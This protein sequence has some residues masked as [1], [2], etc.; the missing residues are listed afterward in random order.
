MQRRWLSSCLRKESFLQSPRNAC[1]L[2]N[3]V[4][5]EDSVT[6][7]PSSAKNTS[8]SQKGLPNLLSYPLS[9]LL[10]AANVGDSG[11]VVSTIM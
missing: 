5:I 4:V 11:Y 3:P 8:N 1:Y 2:G 6:V 9:L 10:K 7:E